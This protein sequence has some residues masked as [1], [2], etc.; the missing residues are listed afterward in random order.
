[1]LAFFQVRFLIRMILYG[2][3][4]FWL[5]LLYHLGSVLGSGFPVPFWQGLKFSLWAQIE[6]LHVY[7]DC[8]VHPGQY[9]GELLVPTFISLLPLLVLSVRWK[10]GDNSKIGSSL[11]SLMFHAIHAVFLGVCLWIAFDP[12]FSPRE[13]NLGLPL[14]YLIALSAGYYAGYFLLV[15]GTRR[16]RPKD[17]PSFL[18]KLGD[19]AIVIGVWVVAALAL[20]GLICKNAP[21]VRA[22]NANTLRKFASLVIGNLP[23][24]AIVLSDDAERMYLIQ[25]A[26]ASEGRAKNYLLLDTAWLPYPQYHHFLH[27][28]AP[29]TWPLLVKPGQTK[30]LNTVGLIELLAYLS[31]TNE[32]YYLHPSFGYYFEEFYL[33]P[34]GLVY[35]LKQLPHDTLMPPP[36]DKKLIALNRS[37]WN[38]AQTDD[39]D[40][41]A[42]AVAPPEPGAPENFVET[43]LDR[44]HVPHEV[45][46]NS[47]LVADYCSRSLDFWG[48][49]LQRLG[50]FAAAAARFRTALEL[51]TNNIAARLNLEVNTNLAA[52]N[53]L[54]ANPS[55][56]N[57][58]QQ[59]GTFSNVSRI[60]TQ[61]GPIDDP[62]FCFLYGYTLAHEN[63]FYRQAVAPLN[64]AVQL[65]PD[66]LPG[67]I[68][69][70][71]V[72]GMN[73]LP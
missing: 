26:L 14:Y 15:F 5:L 13:K 32:L 36:P 61:D 30:V 17:S 38:A 72:Y 28:Q 23:P 3:A 19:A 44:L 21:L 62:A 18:A 37:F 54:S 45:D 50:D 65:D 64:R 39:L 35:K 24:K 1:G 56:S 25:A 47:L 8:V 63:K 73:H 31:R 7:W 10:F 34:H 66:Y 16:P 55:S 27:K 29:Q 20:V 60:L 59:L 41:V 51:N 40:S 48:V 12:P 68:W 57:A 33:E 6:V 71:R 11:T 69:L 49:Q 42:S 43:Q 70:A 4:G 46:P 9:F 67:R 22:N 52:G 58:V 2:L 53:R